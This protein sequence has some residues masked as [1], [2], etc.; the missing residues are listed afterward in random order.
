MCVPIQM[1]TVLWMTGYTRV[2][3]EDL[4]TRESFPVLELIPD[5]GWNGARLHA[6]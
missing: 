3:W 5:K 6:Q 2:Q 4:F 1:M